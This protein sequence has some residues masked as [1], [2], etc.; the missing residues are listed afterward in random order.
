MSEFPTEGDWE[1]LSAYKHVKDIILS[2][3]TPEQLQHYGKSLVYPQ[4]SHWTDFV[5]GEKVKLLILANAHQNSDTTYISNQDKDYK[6]YLE[7]RLGTG[8]KIDIQSYWLKI[9]ILDIP[10]NNNFHRQVMKILKIYDDEIL[11]EIDKQLSKNEII[12]PIAGKSSE[13]VWR[14]MNLINKHLDEKIWMVNFEHIATDCIIIKITKH[15][16]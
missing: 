8:F 3:Y 5:F 14:V 12:Y 2:N 7:G 11:E 6:K 16:I 4:E 10:S 1:A 15:R 13:T 9:K